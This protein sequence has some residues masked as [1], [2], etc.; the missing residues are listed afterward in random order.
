MIVLLRGSTFEFKTIRM[1][2]H[3]MHVHEDT[4]H[5]YY[6]KSNTISLARDNA[7]FLTAKCEN[8]AEF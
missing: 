1:F 2:R 8:N 3:F 4:N 6:G 5:E 7:I